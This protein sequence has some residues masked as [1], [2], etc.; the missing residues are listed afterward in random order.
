M[1]WTK[2]RNRDGSP[3]KFPRKKTLIQTE[4]TSKWSS[5]RWCSASKLLRSRTIVEP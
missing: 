2:Q 5:K 3:L 4:Q 1:M